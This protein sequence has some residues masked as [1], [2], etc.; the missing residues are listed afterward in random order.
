M[1]QP[2]PYPFL[3]A[4]LRRNL[5]ARTTV[6][7]VLS[8]EGWTARM[9]MPGGPA[10][11][12]YSSNDSWWWWPRPYWSCSSCSLWSSMSMLGCCDGRPGPRRL[13]RSMA[14]ASSGPSR[15][16]NDAHADAPHALASFS[17]ASN[18]PSERCWM[19]LLPAFRCRAR[20]RANDDDAVALAA[21]AA[22]AIP[23]VELGSDILQPAPRR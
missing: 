8:G 12:K 11:R 15:R 1:K 5:V 16:S 2:S 14:A 4:P 9:V 3:S 23:R 6:D 21:A 18:P 13:G 17:S 10:E 20:I 19:A 22:A 7:V